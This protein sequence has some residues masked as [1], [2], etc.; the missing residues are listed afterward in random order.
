MA[1][2]AP[3]IAT[4]VIATTVHP[5]RELGCLH[6][7]KGGL[8]KTTPTHHPQNVLWILFENHSIVNSRTVP[9]RHKIAVEMPYKVART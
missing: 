4:V 2:P 1:M 7:R 5:K 9:L 3:N 8:D 6:R